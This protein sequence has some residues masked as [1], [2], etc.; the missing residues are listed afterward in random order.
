MPSELRLV[1]AKNRKAK[2]KMPRRSCK[3]LKFC[4]TQQHTVSPLAIRAMHTARR[5]AYG[6]LLKMS[7]ATTPITIVAP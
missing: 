5:R 6:R 3:P 2:K 7:P 4:V 1:I